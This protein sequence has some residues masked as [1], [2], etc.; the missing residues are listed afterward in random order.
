MDRRRH[1]PATPPALLRMVREDRTV[2]WPHL[3]GDPLAD[4][5]RDDATI[6]VRR[7]IV[8]RALAVRSTWDVLPP[9]KPRRLGRVMEWLAR[10]FT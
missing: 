7:D 5:G 3:V 2:I 9:E 4:D 6:F 1:A 8:K 10:W